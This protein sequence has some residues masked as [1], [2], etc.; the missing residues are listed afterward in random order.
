MQLLLFFR[1]P[2]REASFKRLMLLMCAIMRCARWGRG[3]S[4]SLFL[5]IAEIWM[6]DSHDWDWA[7]GIWPLAKVAS[8]LKAKIPT[9][10]MS[11]TRRSPLSRPVTI[12]VL[13]IKQSVVAEY[14]FNLLL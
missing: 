14:L 11:N 2:S 7:A 5:T 9:D 8:R 4:A 6:V 13:Y 12:G 3:A 10:L 1:E